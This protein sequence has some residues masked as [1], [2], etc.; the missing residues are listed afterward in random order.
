MKNLVCA[1]GGTKAFYYL[2]IIK[3]LEE[4]N[5][6]EEIENMCGTSCGSMIVIALALNYSYDELYNIFKD[7]DLK[8]VLNCDIF[9]IFT[10]YSMYGNDILRKILKILIKYKT[11]KERLSMKEL[12]E[13]SKKKIYIIATNIE[14]GEE[15]IFN[16]END[17]DMDIID[18][19]CAS[20]ALPMIFPIVEINK[21]KYVDGCFMN[22]YPL[23]IFKDDLD[24][25]IGIEIESFCN[26]RK[27]SSF[28]DYIINLLL[29]M[30]KQSGTHKHLKKAKK[31]IFIENKECASNFEITNEKK[32]EMINI[33]YK[34][35]NDILN[36][37]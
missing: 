28:Y 36:Y 5:L 18:I 34:K 35:C 27:I 3:S 11:N 37:S 1:G 15:K 20:C 24:N 7:Y 26:S 9:N 8:N 12:C 22:N 21:N 33:G 29:I 23:D 13:Y 30:C 14:S 2:G 4:H 19:V 31:Y 25:T 17:G 10:N 6:L 32:K 16:R